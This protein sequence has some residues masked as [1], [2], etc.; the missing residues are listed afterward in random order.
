MKSKKLLAKNLRNR[1]F[2]FVLTLCVSLHAQD[3]DTTVDAPQTGTTPTVDVQLPN[4]P[5]PVLLL[6]YERYTGKRVIRDANI[7]DKTL[8]VI[9][10]GKL[11]YEEAA[12]FIEKSLLLNGYAIVPTDQPDQMKIIAFNSD[13]KVSSEGIPIY[14]SPFQ[15][16]ETEEIVTYI[17][18]LSYLTPEEAAELFSNVKDLHT[19]GKITPLQNASAVVITESATNVR[20]FIELRD[21]LDVAP[22]KTVSESI[23]LERADAEEV[24]EAIIDILDLDQESGT[25]ASPQQNGRNIRPG[26]EQALA[27]ANDRLIPSQV[28]G[29]AAFA[30]PNTPKPRVRAIPR[31]NRILVVAAPQDMEYVKDIIA[32]LD[33]PVE[34]ETYMRRKLLYIPVSDFLQ[35][36]SDV[37]LRGLGGENAESGEISGGNENQEGSRNNLSDNTGNSSS[38]FGSETGTGTTGNLGNAGSDEAAAPQSIVIDKTL[39][40]A[41]NVQNTLIASGPPEHLTLICELLEVMDKRPEQIQISAVIAQLNL[42]D[43]FEFGFDFLRTLEPPGMGTFYNS[44]GTFVSR[45]GQSQGLLDFSTLTDPTNLLPAAQGLTYYGQVNKYLDYAIAALENTNRFE[46]LQRPTVYTQNNRLAVIETGQRVAVPRSTLS[47]LDFA[48]NNNANQVVSASIDYI[49]VVLKISVVP[50]INDEGAITLQIQQKND[51]IV[52]SQVIGGDSIPTIQTQTL[53][54]TVIVED[55]GTVLLGGLISENDQ[56][57]ES[58]LPL[59]ANL[60]IVG[61]VFGSTLDNVSRQELLIFIQPKIIRNGLDQFHID[62][63]M[64]DRTRVGPDAVQF[65]VGDESNLESFES[66][67]Y[68]SAEKRIHFF[69]N[70]FKKKTPPPTVRAVPLEPAPL[71]PPHLNP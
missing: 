46:V 12:E 35:I 6:E 7:Q 25:P 71:A 17:M 65:A 31:A 69:R 62:R 10:S 64:I 37:I 27:D 24:A 57:N 11:T 28:R 61:R 42:G 63:E 58:G 55:G 70:L 38:S 48:G 18:P 9:T 26:Q 50:L 34:T 43:D 45:T 20:R 23:Q 67:E 5:I 49:D 36:A 21:H 40:I 68:D 52:G 56:K 66:E 32:H 39:L 3:Q 30:K 15:L 53:G 8:S 16:P 41:D 29:S 19:Y 54:T 47:S 4:T 51:S 44:A 22:V 14:T 2:L 1:F 13:K 33:A 60:P 59:F